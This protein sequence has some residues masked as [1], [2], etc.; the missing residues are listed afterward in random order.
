MA[1]CTNNDAGLNGA[2]PAKTTTAPST[3]GLQVSA[4]G[5]ANAIFNVNKLTSA[6]RKSVV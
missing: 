5:G 2:F 4:N 1:E 3:T 6:D